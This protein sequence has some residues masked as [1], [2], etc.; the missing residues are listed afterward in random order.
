ME[1]DLLQKL[2]TISFYVLQ[3]LA[4]G[5]PALGLLLTLPLTPGRGLINSVTS[6]SFHKE[7]CHLTL[8]LLLDM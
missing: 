4:G 3:L 2:Q 8:L 1:D 5:V 7:E 6:N